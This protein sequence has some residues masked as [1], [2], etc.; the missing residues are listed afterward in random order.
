MRPCAGHHGV[1][2]HCLH[3]PGFPQEHV[4]NPIHNRYKSQHCNARTCAQGMCA[5]TGNVVKDTR[6]SPSISTAALSIVHIAFAKKS[7]RSALLPRPMFV[8]GVE[9]AIET[10]TGQQV[11]ATDSGSHLD[12]HHPLSLQD[13]AKGPQ[14]PY[15][16]S[17]NFKSKP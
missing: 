9:A 15:I 14:V 16:A 12:M 3:F 8:A 11:D 13:W 4:C 7:Y 6:L 2:M 1:Q 5:C 10:L 17:S